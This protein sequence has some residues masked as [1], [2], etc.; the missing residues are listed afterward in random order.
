[1]KA[2]NIG[3]MGS[4]VGVVTTLLAGRLRNRGS[5]SSAEKL[6]FS[7]SKRLGRYATIVTISGYRGFS[8]GLKWPELE[9]A[10]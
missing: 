2:L 6:F 10:A 1:M 5:I 7:L 3:S 9:A 4:S 8:L